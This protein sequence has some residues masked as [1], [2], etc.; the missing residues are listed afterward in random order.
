MNLL[1]I[2]WPPV[3]GH[4]YL[5]TARRRVL[6]SINFTAG[7]LGLILSAHQLM[8]CENTP[9]WLFLVQQI[10]VLS[11]ILSPLYL[12]RMKNIRGAAA[13]FTILGLILL[14]V[15][16]YIGGGT[17]TRTATFMP[18]VVL[19]STLVLG[20]QFGGG[21]ALCVIGVLIGLH[22]VP[23]T[24]VGA[25][26]DAGAMTEVTFGLVFLTAFIYIAAAIFEHEMVRVA[27][28]NTRALRQAELASNAKSDFLAT[29]SHEIRTPLN[30]VLGVAALLRNTDLDTQQRHF[31]ETIQKSGG[32]LL[33]ILNDVLDFSKIEAGK[34][35]ID[36]QP[37]RPCQAFEPIA[38][39]FEAMARERGL[40]F[41]YRCEMDA[42]HA[43]I[44]DEARLQQI[45]NN[46][47]GNALKFTHNGKITL[48]VSA[49]RDGDE[50]E[51][52]IEVSDTGIGI[53]PDRLATIFDDFAQADRSTARQYGGTGLGL[54]IT[55]RLTERMGGSIR[56]HSSVGE[57]SRFRV[58]LRFE[59]Q[60]PADTAGIAVERA[61]A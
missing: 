52:A 39:L 31:I 27:D 33:T 11:L 45:V 21:V 26:G 3:E 2:Y 47:V 41:V 34:L 15:S 59:V 43:V 42:P 55:R 6:Y 60:S 7:T 53:A 61:P 46:L 13:V 32:S 5:A 30:G 14:G 20:R 36:P 57:G 18:L 51:M 25:P 29:M 24:G 44:G 1:S 28:S 4:D 9:I 50:V 23:P 19:S 37:F 56:A 10:F 8:S 40:D 48:H 54:A 16:A 49:T 22:S 17:L 58:D 35:E 12:C 38:A